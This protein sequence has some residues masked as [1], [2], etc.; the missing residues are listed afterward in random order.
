[1]RRQQSYKNSRVMRRIFNF[2]KTIS[3]ALIFFLLLQVGF[4]FAPNRA[5]A[6]TKSWDFSSSTDYTFDNTKIEFSSGQAQLKATSSPAWYNTSWTKRKPITITGSTAGAQTNYQVKITVTYDSDIQADFDDVRFTDSDG[7]TL[8]NYWLESKTDSTTADFWVEVLS[9]P[10]Y[11]D[12]ATVYMYYGNSGASSAS[13]G[14]NTF[15]SGTDFAQD[16]GFAFRDSGTNEGYGDSSGTIQ[17]DSGKLSL[18]NIDRVND[19]HVRKSFLPGT[20]SIV[21][22]AT[23]ATYLNRPEDVLVDGNYAYIPS[24]AGGNLSVYN[25]SNPNSPAFVSSFTDADLTEAMGVAKNGNTVYLTSWHNHKLLILDATDPSNITKISSIEIGTTEGGGD[26]DELRKVF[27]LDGYAYVTHSH[28]QKLYIVDVSNP[29]SPSITGS[30]ATG[31]GAF[32]VFV[33]GNYAYVGGCF[34]GSSLKVI[35]VSNKTSPSV[36]KTLSSANYSCTAGFANSGNDLYAVYYSTNN[37]VTFDITDPP[38]TSQKGI[39]NSA[40]LNYPNRLVVNGTTAYVA[41]AVGDAIVSVN[42][43]DSTN[44]ALGTV[45][46]DT[47]LDGAYGVTYSNNKVFA[48]GRNA[49]SLVVYD[50]SIT[51]TGGVSNNFSVR[52]KLK[53][54]AATSGAWI[55]ATGISQDGS[56]INGFASSFSLNPIWYNNTLQLVEF[57]G[58]GETYYKTAASAVNTALN[59]TYILELQKNGNSASLS[60]Y[61]TNGT[62]VGASTIASLTNPNTVFYYLMPYQNVA[63]NAN[64]GSGKTSSQEI[65]YSFLRNFV[66]P[67]PTYSIGSEVNLYPTDSPSIHSATTQP[68]TLLSGFSE[69]ATKNGGEIK[70][71]ISNDGGTTW[72]WYNSGWTT[73]SA[74]YTE[75]N[76]ASVINTNIATFP[77]GS[78]QFLFKAYLNSDGTQLVQLDSVDLT[79][80]NTRTLTYTAGA[81]GSITG[82]SPQTVDYGTDGTA[83]TAVPDTGYHFVDWSD[84]STTNPRTDT[85]VTANI[86]VTAN[87]EATAPTTY[88]ITS[89][90][91]SNGSISPSGATTVN[92]GDN[93]T[94]TITANS[95][96][97]ISDVMV[98]GSSVGAVSSYTFNNVTAGHTISATFDRTSSGGGGCY[99]CYVNPV[100]PSGGFKMS[101]NSGA[102]TTA[103][104]NVFLWFNAGADIKK[105]AISMTGDFT[106]A[107][108]ENYMVSRQWDLCSK[109]GGAV[110]SPTCPDGKYTV[111]AK[112]YTA[113]GRSSDTSVAS[114]TITLKSSAVTENLQQYANLPFSNPFT[115]Y[116]QYRQ[117]S[118]DIKRLQI[119]L[120]SDPDTR[121]ADT[122]VGSP[123]HE[124]NYFGLLTYKAVIKFQEKYAKDILAPWGFVKGTGYVGKTTLQK[125]N[126]LISK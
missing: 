97:H 36:V 65:Y 45:K 47:L 117:S 61:Q 46:S 110:K 104:R 84:S 94:F 2:Q 41:S 118:S 111:Y 112:F 72:Y 26:P 64:W 96:Y 57:F 74:G 119:F 8:L 68:F 60:I 33:K 55:P 53:I 85:N 99:G 63:S 81:N 18:V 79:Y 12:T 9:I 30:V 76:T 28:D 91:G 6:A 86:T 107:S 1:M 82:D 70:Y 92:N 50:P 124:T 66:S 102:S 58:V 89:S 120:N 23:S 109:L 88:T 38:N 121:I 83:V 77:T 32:A 87:F 93:Q 14:A 4:L 73:T 122:G 80:A 62:L 49:N 69:T 44:P 114:S 35:D 54:S 25:V 7:T 40:S 39:L 100:V 123:G 17:S 56:K 101:I 34:V 51:D 108:Q 11:P 125:I 43:S 22:S 90:A 10:A 115:N 71:Q 67:E 13:N 103:N 29:V 15:I 59:T 78:G 16:D 24:R 98:D 3:F 75:A 5:Q 21:G 37:F 20:S 19:S 27:Y 52:T 48:V 105:M 113:Y 31:D 106:D 126:Q 116:L 42:I 95:G